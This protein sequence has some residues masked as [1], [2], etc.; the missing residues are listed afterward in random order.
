[1]NKISLTLLL[2]LFLNPSLIFTQSLEQKFQLVLDSFYQAEPEAVGIMIH[3]EAPDKNISWTSAVGV[4]DKNENDKI[5]Q[6]QPALIASNTKT[7]V[8]TAI[9]KLVENKKLKLE[10]PI[11]KIIKRKTRKKLKRDGY[12][13]DK[14]Q[15]KHLLSHTS[16]IA[17]YVDDDY[18]KWVN[19]KPNY[20]WTRD[21]QIQRTV[22]IGKPLSTPGTQYK[23]GDINYLLLTEIIERKTKKPFYLAIRKLIDYK[24]HGLNSTW[25][26]NL[27]EKPGN[28]QPL[29]HQYWA[30]KNWDSYDLN[31]S[32]DLYGGGG[33]ASTTKD[34]ALFFQNL[35]EGKII[36]DKNL[37][38]SMHAFVLPKEDSRY[39]LGIQQLSFKGL[40]AYYHGGFWGTDAMHIPALNTT[41]T[42]FTLQRNSRKINAQLSKKIIALLQQ[43]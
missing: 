37:L 9:L 6:H 20:Q 29:V 25:F 34:L 39:C 26:I 12:Q 4:S 19:D 18:F 30:K 14:I 41:I 7:Y 8:S 27:E 42:V 21:E 35:F 23:Y 24:S 36:Q 22:D 31:P 15:I 1:M 32:W 16:G 28:T 3:V 5:N 40:A 2:F 11:K 17:D 38:E 33:L 43:D 10:Q 13:L